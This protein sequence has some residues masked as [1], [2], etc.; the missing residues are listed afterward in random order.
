M[1]RVSTSDSV[2][3]QSASALLADLA[4]R[5][6]SAEALM[7]ATLDRIAE[8]NPAVNAVVG[9]AD[10]G[11]LLAQARALD[12]GP[13]MGPLHGLPLAI[14]DLVNVQ[15]IR[16]TR[17]S[18]IFADF[19]PESDD[20]LAARLRA[21]GA[22]L[23]GKTNVPE[24]GLGSH[25]FNPVYGR[26]NNPYN[27]A[28]T[29][30]GSSGGAGVALALGMVAL[31]DGSDMMGSLRNPAAWSNVYGFRPS[32]GRV[33]AEP[34]Q[35][36]TL[37]KMATSGPMARSPADVALLLDVMSHA[38]PLRPDVPAPAPTAPLHPAVLTRMRIGWLSDWSGALPM[39]AG[40][41]EQCETSL[42][43]LRDLGA[44]V[45][46]VPAPLPFETLWQSW[47]TLRSWQ[48]G[49]ALV[50]LQDNKDL[51]K[52][53]V[54]WELERAL[55]MT[56]L[57]AHDASAAR[58]QWLAH[59]TELFQSYDALILPTTQVWPFDIN[60]PWPTEIA[61]VEMDTYH[62]WMA[63]TVPV[64]LIGLP[65]LSMPAGFGDSGLPVGMQLFGPRGADAKILAMGE[66]YHRQTLWPQRHP[67][68]GP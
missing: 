43:V 9:L 46:H 59:A 29:C 20:V 5:R 21:S 39:E 13:V 50:A 27:P 38:D 31:A 2:L 4:S 33:P 53:S 37:H 54:Q 57:E 6:L 22:I 7:V 47:I 67:P 34:A 18:P 30:G 60:L 19:V 56:A 32:W 1:D 41:L 15:G 36:R 62:R 63:V 8:R 55:R 48:V 28:R 14:K 25:T 26:T 49:A 23:I 12:A 16:S 52:D 3:D 40:I 58:A 66:A 51:M 65:S 10:P 42:Q 68:I 11:A 24:F 61:G 35:D 45:E 17:G 44:S 64:S